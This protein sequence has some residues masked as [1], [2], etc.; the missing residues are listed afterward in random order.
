MFPKNHYNYPVEPPT[1]AEGPYID[2]PPPRM[3][4]VRFFLELGLQCIAGLSLLGYY[5]NIPMVWEYKAN[6]YL[7]QKDSK[8]TSL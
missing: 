4:Y 3:N 1:S 6:C 7:D 2:Y 5:Q 8:K